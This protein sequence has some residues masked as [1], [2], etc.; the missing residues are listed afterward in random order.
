MPLIL[1]LRTIY[2]ETNPPKTKSKQKT[3]FNIFREK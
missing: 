1:V 2:I 3:F